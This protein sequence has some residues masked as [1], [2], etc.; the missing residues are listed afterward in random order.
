MMPSLRMPTAPSTQS[1]LDRAYEEYCQRR[2]A[3]EAVD[4]E[5]FLARHSTIRSSLGRM[6]EI[7]Q[8]LVAEQLDSEKA[9]ISW[10]ELG[11]S[12]LGFDLLR[13]LGEGAFSRVY[14]ATDPALGNRPVALKL[15]SRGES[16]AYTL[17]RLSHANVTPIHSVQR[18][19]GSGL[20][21]LCMPYLGSAT[22]CSVLD[23]ILASPTP[24]RRADVLLQAARDPAMDHGEL[25]PAPFAS[26]A[27][28]ADGV[29]TLFAG[30][31]E[32]LTALHEERIV[33]RDLKPSNVLLRPDG[34]PVLLDFNLAEDA[35]QGDSHFGGTYQYMAPEQLEYMRAG[36]GQPL[37]EIDYRADLFALGVM[38]WQVLT[39]EHPFGPLPPKLAGPDLRELL[40]A[41]QLEGFQARV[42]G[43]WHVR[44]ELIELVRA[45]LSVDPAKRP[46]S[47]DEVRRLLLPRR[48]ARRW[49]VAIAAAAILGLGYA[50]VHALPV[51]EP[52]KTVE[53]APVLNPYR[54]GVAAC[55]AGN[56][57]TALASFDDAT[58]LDPNNPRPW[59]AR[60][61][62]GLI[63]CDRLSDDDKKQAK[64]L[65]ATMVSDLGVAYRLAA[66]AR[67]KSLAAAAL[68]HS[69]Y[70]RKSGF[71]ETRYRQALEDGWD[72]DAPTDENFAFLHNYANMMT[73]AGLFPGNDPRVKGKRLREGRDYVDRLIRL[74]PGFQLAYALRGRIQML[75]GNE[76][77]QFVP[78]VNQQE[79]HR[80]AISDF[81]NALRLGL[82]YGE[83]YYCRGITRLAE[84]KHDANIAAQCAVD[85]V[86]FFLKAVEHGCKP[87]DLK[88]LPL[89]AAINIRQLPAY[90]DLLDR[91]HIAR[92]EEKLP[93]VLPLLTQLP[94]WLE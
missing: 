2:E 20:Y 10:P 57:A 34:R 49:R 42:P 62:V 38:L 52:K 43:G 37:P 46:A 13:Q 88:S 3:G 65:V 82:E 84:A 45:C 4:V 85:A 16:E 56:L 69:D 27:S 64:D 40:R 36:F 87:A 1:L 22:L 54:D 33:H 25:P 74:N 28:Y 30:I 93:R 72:L 83:L 91:Q 5:S 15:T 23:A 7:D 14:L 39:G 68:G 67:T 41:R 92:P 71:P 21:A 18:E 89:P 80:S 9:A 75:L 12:F 76:P 44:R 86:P 8:Q 78:D 6:I 19:P 17:G 51:R 60:G 59:L 63:I 24:P 66:D 35:K 77:K 32:A 48:T 58:K 79:C 47:A 11:Q 55:R 26:T 29:R 73:V 61:I 50:T 94:A 31:C 90:R 70:Q 53:P 81:D